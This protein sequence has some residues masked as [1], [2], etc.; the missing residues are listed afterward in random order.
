MG[1]LS[2]ALMKTRSQSK[3]SVLQN[4]WPQLAAQGSPPAYEAPGPQ[5]GLDWVGRGAAGLHPYS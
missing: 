1:R 3:C 5:C 2:S 4:H